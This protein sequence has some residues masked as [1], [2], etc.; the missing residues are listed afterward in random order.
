MEK[1]K[2]LVLG[3]GNYGYS[4]ASEVLPACSDYAELVGVVERQKDKWEGIGENILKFEDLE[5]ALKETKPELVINV[6]PP[7]LHYQLSAML[8][9]RGIAVLCEKPIADTYENA[10]KMGE[11]LEQTKGFL[12]IGENY[13]YHSVF[14]K[15]KELLLNGMLGNIHSVECT[16]RHYHPDYSMF[17]HGRL[18][19]PLLED[20]TIHHLD[21]ARYLTGKEPVKVWCKEYSAEY[22]WYGKRPASAVITTEMTGNVMFHYNGTLASP[23]STTNWNGNWEIECD[24]GVLKIEEDK[25][26]IYKEDSVVEVPYVKEAE[27]SRVMMLK[28]ACYALKEKHKAPTCYEDNIKTFIWMRKL[29]EEAEREK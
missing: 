13:R 11:V 29:I 18:A 22:S 16:F 15:A 24:N 9:K 20:V 6:T 27:D 2:V 8:M 12:M 7:D 1:V 23:V 17:Y 21:L 5:I 19:H 10:L 4:W 14:R 3:L 28:E 26:F 25:I